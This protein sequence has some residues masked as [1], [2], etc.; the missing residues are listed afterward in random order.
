[1]HKSFNIFAAVT[2]TA[3]ALSLA[4]EPAKATPI[5][6]VRVANPGNANDTTGYGAVAYT[7][8][9]MKYEFT[10]TQYAEFLNAIDPQGIN[11]QR[12]WEAEMS[13]SN[14]GG[15]NQV[16]GNP[17]GSRYVVKTNFDDKPVNFMSSFSAARVANW[18]QNGSP[19]SPT[20]TNASGTAPQN[21]GVYAIGTGTSGN[22]PAKSAGAIYWIPLENEWYKA[23]Y[24]NPTLNSGS[25]GYTTYGN[26]FST[27]S[28]TVTASITGVGSAGGIGN[29]AN[30]G[31]A[32]N[33]NGTSLGA[34]TSVGTNGAANSYGA[35]DMSGNTFEF[36]TLTGGSSTN[37]GVRGGSFAVGPPGFLSGTSRF[38][39]STSTIDNEFGFRLVAVPEPES[40]ALLATGGVAF[41]AG[42]IRRRRI[43]SA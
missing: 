18:L 35:F 6:W 7:F 11:P 23:A 30:Y 14:Q 42:L 12:V 39:F 38:E 24:Y 32:A 25:G 5:E 13:S 28:G 4:V 22:L 17:L 9:I 37:A 26:G 19:V 1:M 10:N 27:T 29:F 8:D 33:W 36:N 2:V 3:L 43:A 21:T 16:P 31:Q 34:P 41:A 40:L 15:I 20:T